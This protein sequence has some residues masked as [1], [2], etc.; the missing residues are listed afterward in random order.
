M[1]RKLDGD[2]GAA[3]GTVGGGRGD[4]HAYHCRASFGSGVQTL[5][6]VLVVTQMSL[7]YRPS[8]TTTS[9]KS[10]SSCFARSTGQ[11]SR[12]GGIMF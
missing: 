7:C 4:R 10:W 6:S 2:D 12:W 8:P 5:Y 3:A 1:A 11:S 9:K